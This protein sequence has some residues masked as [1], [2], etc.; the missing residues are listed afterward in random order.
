MFKNVTMKTIIQSTLVILF[1]LFST[2]MMAQDEWDGTVNTS[3]NSTTENIFRSGNI[4]IGTNNPISPLSVNANGDTRYSIYSFTNSANNGSTALFADAAQPLGGA[5][6][7]RAVIGRIRSGRGYTYGMFGSAFNNTASNAGRAYGV[8]GSAGNATDHYNYGVYGRI[9]G[10]HNGTAI[11]GHDYISHPGW[12]G[13][14]Q[15]TWAGYFVG[16]VHV[17]NNMGIQTTSPTSAL[18]VGG[19]GDTRYTTYSFTDGTTN[20]ST[21]LFGESALPTGFADRVRGVVGTIESGRGYTSG[22]LG[23]AYTDTPSSAGRAYGL[24]GRAGNATDN[25]N[26]GVYGMLLGQQGGTAVLGHDYINHAGWNGSTQGTWAGYFVGNVH[27]THQMSIG[28]INMPAM[29]TVGGNDYLLYV[30]GGALFEEVKVETG[31][32]DYVFEDD[33]KLTSLEAVEA[34]IEENGYLHNTPSAEEVETEGLNIGD[35]TVNQQEKIEEIFL[36][37][38]QMNKEIQSLKAENK[39]LKTELLNAKK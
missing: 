14:T 3:V 9:I 31:W 23:V 39:A 29:T 28:T 17:T 7:V 10:D 37:L 30:G 34:H 11:L 32:A 25:Y 8:Y 2:M 13:N 4:G 21:A 15:G 36:H 27:T 1:A 26:Y 6:H 35:M 16:D 12:N 20:G 33:Y 38:I 19:S 5:D 24:E 22:V 18:S